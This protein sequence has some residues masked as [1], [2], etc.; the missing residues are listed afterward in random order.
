MPGPAANIEHQLSIFGLCEADDH[1][2]PPGQDAGKSGGHECIA[3]TRLSC[4]ET[5]PSRSVNSRRCRGCTDKGQCL[6]GALMERRESAVQ[7]TTHGFSIAPCI[8]K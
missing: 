8:P 1:V 7:R 5:R 4:G 6:G 2:S 3:L